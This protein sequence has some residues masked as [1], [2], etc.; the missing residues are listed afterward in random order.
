MG[1]QPYSEPPE[2]ASGNLPAGWRRPFIATTMLAALLSL[3]FSAGFWQLDRAGQ[4][5][6]ILD[7]F[8]SASNGA[9]HTALVSDQAAAALRFRSFQLTGRYLPDKQVLLDN[10]TDGGANGY[11]VLTAFRTG[12]LYVMVNRGWIRASGN[13]QL[14]PDISVG[15]EERTITAR[16]NTFPSPGLR[17]EQPAE[18][19]TGQP[20]RLL[21]PDRAALQQQLGIELPDYQ[22]QLDPEQSDGYLRAW[23]VVESGP[24]KHLGYAFQWFSFA[25]LAVIFYLILIYQWWRSRDA[26]NN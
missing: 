13:R 3:F 18:P 6:A 20:A 11:Q 12:N 15:S 7:D 1:T 5:Q 8:A 17:L 10:M 19:P 14:L 9:H 22:L 4:K 25:A 21:F 26:S 2:P 23:K 24:E 16:L